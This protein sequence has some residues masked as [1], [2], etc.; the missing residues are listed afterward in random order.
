MKKATGISNA[1]YA[2]F[3]TTNNC[4]KTPQAIAGLETLSIS[5][6][7]A[8]GSNYADNLRNIYIKEL[9]GADLSLAFSNISRKIEAEL[10]GQVHA[11][12]QLEY[13]TTAA[14]PQVAILFEKNY[15]DGSSDRIVYY[16]CK[17]AKDN[18]DGETKTDSFNFT[19][20]TLS[21]QAIPMTGKIKTKAST[22]V[23]VDLT[24]VLKFVMD[25]ATLPAQSP[26]SNEIY[27]KFT[28][29]FKKVQFKE[30]KPTE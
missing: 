2:V 20:D 25:S 12:G 26:D 1:H 3:D 9:V 19:G 17:L 22:G 21:G 16:N 5:E 28:E 10:T 14:A 13:K 29:F 11:D 30:K 6:T 18:E 23:D 8:E 24:G 15:S 4:Y 7:Y 27:K